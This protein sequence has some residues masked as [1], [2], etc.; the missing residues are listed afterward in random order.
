MRV[1]LFGLSPRRINLMNPMFVLVP[2]VLSTFALTL[3]W[4]AH[5]MFMCAYVLDMVLDTCFLYLDLSI[6]VSLISDLLLIL[7]FPFMLLVNACTC[8][9]ETHHLI[10]YTCDCLYT[11]IGFILRTRWIFFW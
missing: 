3:F 7:W 9:P 8:M 2:L 5:C 6:H 1:S 11:P 10:M 4:M